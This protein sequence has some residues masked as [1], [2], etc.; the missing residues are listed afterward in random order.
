MAR[1]CWVAGPTVRSASGT[2]A[3]GALLGQ[4]LPGPAPRTEGRG[5]KLF[6]KCAA[7]HTLTGDGGNRAGPPL[8]GLFGRRAGSVADYPYS[9]AL[10]DSGIV[11]TEE[12]VARLF[13]MG[14]DRFVPGSKMPLQR[15]TDPRDRGDLIDYLKQMS[16]S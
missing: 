10:R 15:L 14:P 12:T 9:P 4:P 8:A 11:W 6:A 13:D 5:P 7:C 3:T 16:A 1:A 2:P